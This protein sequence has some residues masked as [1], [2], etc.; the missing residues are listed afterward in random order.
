MLGAVPIHSDQGSYD[1][2]LY[3]TDALLGNDLT[4]QITPLAYFV[5]LMIAFFLFSALTRKKERAETP[6]CEEQEM[7][8]E[9]DEDTVTF[10]GSIVPM[11]S[12]KSQLKKISNKQQLICI[13]SD[14][15]IPYKRVMPILELIKKYRLTNTA[16][17][18]TKTPQLD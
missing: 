12:L 17:I 7:T 14:E 2:A 1:E 5:A 15:S 16:I 6:Q 8:I 18:R 10:N 11:N 13:R 3:N 4:L 9:I